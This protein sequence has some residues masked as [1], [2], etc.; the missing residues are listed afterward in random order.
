VK[1]AKDGEEGLR[2]AGE[3]VPDLIICDVMMP[4]L[5][6]Y[7]VCRALKNEIATSHIPVILLTAKAAEENI[8]Q[9][10]ETGADDYITKPFS[11]R[12][13]SA[14]IKNLI[15][16]R[17]QFQQN[18]NREMTLQPA[19]MQVPSIDKEF[20]KDMQKVI[21]E[22]LSEPEFNVD[23]LSRKLYMSHATLYRKIHA[24]TGETPT[25]FI[26][27]CR[28]KRGAE[29]LKSKHGN[30]GDVAFEVGFSST[31][32]FIRCFKEKFHR[33]PSSFIVPD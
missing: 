26:R 2:L 22:N 5:D 10:L 19:K 8:I 28:L 29:L 12:I 7:E 25:D 21:N 30:V 3:I 18:L 20:L 15:E 27:T 33:L 32:Y 16:L 24:L 4:G 31:S 14:R 17:R 1:G 11:T 23:Q 6:G 9:G 13:L